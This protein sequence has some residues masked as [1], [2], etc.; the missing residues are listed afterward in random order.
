MHQ[1]LLWVGFN[2]F[3]LVM[4]AIDLGLF[5]RK[6][7]S[8]RIREAAIWCG[9]CVAT[10]LI[11]AYGIYYYRN[12]YQSLAFL[13]GYVVEM[14]LSVDNIFVF[15]LIFAYFN[16]PAQYQHRALFWGIIGALVLRGAMIGV[17]VTLVQAFGWIMYVFGAFLVYTGLKMAFQKDEDLEPE[18]NPVLRFVR[19]LI[20]VSSQYHGEKF[21][22]KE[23]RA[24]SWRWV[25][26][27][28]FVVLVMIDV[29]DLIFAVDSIPAV[30]GVVREKPGLLHPEDVPFLAYTSNVFAI[31]CL[32]A[33]YFIVA[34]LVRQ[35][36]FLQFALSIILSF[37]GVKMLIVHWVDL[38]IGW[39]LLFIAAVLGL[40][41][42][43][44]ILFPKQ[45]ED[46]A[47][48]HECPLE[49]PED[50]KS[51]IEEES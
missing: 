1:V 38:P 44:S 40:S 27:P 29:A 36:R 7:H 48:A 28:L 43:A 4:M 5:H 51:R 47:P 22:V 10:A 16:V 42:V 12:G 17:G 9:I 35:F 11:F 19:R 33:L 45:A 6:A 14:A 8:V 46:Y 26:T 34:N 20:P 23:E 39:S 37:V 25:A 50:R 15:V 24:G 2:L 32:R 13:T 21:L 30:L 49:I 3:V 41:V 31:M 18:A